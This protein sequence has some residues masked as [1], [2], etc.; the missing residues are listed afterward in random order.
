MPFE[1]RAYIDEAGDDG[2]VTNPNGTGSSRWMVLSA[3]VIRTKNEP[4]L[5]RCL[6]QTRTMF[7][8]PPL[9][10]LHFR[11][12]THEKKRA[13]VAAIANLPVRTVSVLAHKFSDPA[14][15]TAPNFT[16]KDQFYRYISRLLL[17]RISWLCRDHR[18]DSGEVELIFSNRGSMSYADVRAYVALLK[19]KPE[20][21]IAWSVVDPAAIKALSHEKRAGLQAADAV[22]SS[23][24]AGL[25]VNAF[26]QT[27]WS[28]ATALLPT[29]YRYKSKLWGYGIKWW[30]NN[31]L[32]KTIAAAPYVQGAA[33]WK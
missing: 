15:P 13:Y 32:E 1:F 5:I 14:N 24:F 10:P 25:R 23:C 17:E 9:T 29:F 27:E 18:K 19:T 20:V 30:P 28:Y 4:H 7:K 12:L 3:L 11:D 21:K 22:A 2:F 8:R 6:A 16:E 26:G 33:A 31:E